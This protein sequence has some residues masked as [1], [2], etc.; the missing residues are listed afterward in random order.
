MLPFLHN[1]PPYKPHGI[2]RLCSQPHNTVTAV[3]T[4]PTVWVPSFV[5]DTVPI[6][7]EYL[8]TDSTNIY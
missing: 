2:K 6:F 3:N 5:E 4:G 7:K 8:E 1:T